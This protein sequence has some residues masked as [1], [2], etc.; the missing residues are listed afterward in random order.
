MKVDINSIQTFTN[1]K[2]ND[3]VIIKYRTVDTEGNTLRYYQ[4]NITLAT[5]NAFDRIPTV[6]IEN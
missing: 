6:N 2:L 4:F 3:D 5:Q 1:P